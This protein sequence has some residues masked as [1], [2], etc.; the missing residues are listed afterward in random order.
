MI[1]ATF[2][3]SLTCFWFFLMSIFDVRRYDMH[4]SIPIIV[5]HPKKFTALINEEKNR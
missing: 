5:P 2:Y 1:N 3:F 4:F